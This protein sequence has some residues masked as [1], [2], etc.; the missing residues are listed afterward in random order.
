MA[1]DAAIAEDMTEEE[2]I[3]LS[4]VDKFIEQDVR[5]YAH[6]LEAKDEYPT[7]IAD[8]LADLGLMGA[9][10]GEEYGGLGLSARTYSKIV[11]KVASCWMSVSGIFNS[12]LIA[13]AAVERFGTEE[14]KQTWLPKMAAGEMRGGIALTEPDCGT[15]L[16]AV[17]TTAK[18]DGNEYVL[19]PRPI[20]AT[21]A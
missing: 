3:I 11:S 2:R 12:H 10:I 7:E 21:R 16:Q 19:T 5:P 14:Q 17:R 15:D 6:D 18:K 20:P 1:P 13:A 9:T 4:S 8:K